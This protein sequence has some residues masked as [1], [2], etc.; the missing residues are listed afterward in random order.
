MDAL[1][2]FPTKSYHSVFS[3]ELGRLCIPLG[4]KRQG[5]RSQVRPYWLYNVDKPQE[6]RNSCPWL[7][8]P[9]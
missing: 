8:L 9:G 2:Q 7:P 1:L 5:L 6:G 3:V 4:S